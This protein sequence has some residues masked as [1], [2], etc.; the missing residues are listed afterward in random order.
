MYCVPN[1]TVEIRNKIDIFS[2]S[3]TQQGWPWARNENSRN[4]IRC[5]F[6][7]QYWCVLWVA[8]CRDEIKIQSAE[9]KFISQLRVAR[10]EW[11]CRSGA[12]QLLV[13]LVLIAQQLRKSQTTYTRQNVRL[14]KI[15][16]V[17]M[18]VFQYATLKDSSPLSVSLYMSAI[19]PYCVM[20]TIH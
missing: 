17:K 4:F 5:W 13:K 6:L 12:C 15:E 16:V 14:L 19:Q 2:K 1:E 10:Q 8:W 11:G 9:I 7:F 18:I 3:M 20:K